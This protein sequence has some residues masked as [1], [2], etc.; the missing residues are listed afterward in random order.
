MCLLGRF[1]FVMSLKAVAFAKNELER[2]LIMSLT[3]IALYGLGAVVVL[4]A[5]T[6]LLPRHVSVQRSASF[7]GNAAAIIA[8]AA[9]NEGYQRFNPYKNSDPNLKTEMFG[10]ATGV[11][12]GFKFESKDGSGTQTITAIAADSVTY[13]IDLGAMGKPTSV[14]AVAPDGDK[15]KVTWRTD[16]DM[17]M[18]PIGR[19][20]GL[21]IDGMLGKTYE[22]GL[23]NIETAVNS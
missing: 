7:K 14:I 2:E 12:S 5:G 19:V 1:Q 16:M 13:A 6:M 3:S 21:F 11:G 10:P 17:G 23:K 8:M 15:T 4:A 20:M 18:N 22:T 9:S